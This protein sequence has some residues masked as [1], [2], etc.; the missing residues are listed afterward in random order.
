MSKGRR[1]RWN[2]GRLDP[3][4]AGPGGL[5]GPQLVEGVGNLAVVGVDVGV[6]DPPGILIGAGEGPTQAGQEFERCL[7]GRAPLAALGG[8]GGQ[9]SLNQ[10]NRGGG[11][12]L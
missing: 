5:D 4:Q 2:N 1:R 9:T 10:T 8:L 6:G 7:R 11:E 12:Q 3:P